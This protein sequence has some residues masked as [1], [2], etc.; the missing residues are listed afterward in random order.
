[1][2]GVKSAI[3]YGLNKLRFPSAVR[4]GS[5]IRGRFTLLDA[6]VVAPGVVQI[7]EN[8]LVEVEGQAKPACIAESVIRIAF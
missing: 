7:T 6:T 1:M 2:P 5:R 8:F 4:V 3:N